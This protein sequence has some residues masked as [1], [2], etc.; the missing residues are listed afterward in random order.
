MRW[1]FAK[2]ATLQRSKIEAKRNLTSKPLWSLFCT[3]NKRLPNKKTSLLYEDGHNKKDFG[4]SKR[5]LR[6]PKLN[7]NNQRS[8]SIESLSDLIINNP[9]LSKILRPKTQLESLLV[10][11]NLL[12]FCPTCH[13]A[14]KPMFNNFHQVNNCFDDYWQS[15]GSKKDLDNENVYAQYETVYADCQSYLDSTDE[16]TIS[17][18]ENSYEPWVSSTMKRSA[19]D[20][21]TMYDEVALD[22][23]Y[24]NNKSIEHIKSKRSALK[25]CATQVPD[26]IQDVK[27]VRREFYVCEA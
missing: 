22:D 1:P 25:R 15:P 16:D 3:L 10:Y 7:K 6:Q 14:V 19:E 20:S 9:R 21:C 8:L 5:H 13:S 27:R 24:E 26:S 11:A 12:A 17:V 23:S 2:R 18:F 4:G